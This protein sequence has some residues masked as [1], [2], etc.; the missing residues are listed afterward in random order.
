MPEMKYATTGPEFQR[1]AK[2]YVVNMLGGKRKLHKKNGCQHASFFAEYYD[3]DSKED[4]D[5]S[6]I[7]FTI[8]GHCLGY[9][10]AKHKTPTELVETH[11]NLSGAVRKKYTGRS[12]DRIVYY[13]NKKKNVV[14]SCKNCGAEL[15]GEFE[16]ADSYTARKLRDHADSN[17]RNERN[18]YSPDE[19]EILDL[20]KTYQQVDEIVQLVDKDEEEANRE[21]KRALESACP[22]CGAKLSNEKGFFLPDN[23]WFREDHHFVN[24][25]EGTK[26]LERR[27]G[28]DYFWNDSYEKKLK[29]L[30]PIREKQDRGQACRD[31]LSYAE[32]CDLPAFNSSVNAGGIKT[33]SEELKKYILHLIQLENNIYSLREQLSDLYYRR[34]GNDRAVV[35]GTCEPAYE[36]RLELDD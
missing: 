18:K 33:N 36:I 19:G 8:C 9:Q 11:I 21:Y 16:F 10:I 5:E 13:D 1:D 3:F 14:F 30:V 27:F 7:E 20:E 23:D 34:L 15:Y 25:S 4:A 35:F 29:K 24:Y 22:I 32:K 28:D 26:E 12:W 31:A 6:G 2:E 17:L